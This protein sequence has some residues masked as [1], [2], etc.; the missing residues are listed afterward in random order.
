MSFT[1]AGLKAHMKII[2]FP[3]DGRNCAGDL[4][5]GE[6]G[7]TAT[8]AATPAAKAAAAAT[9]TGSAA[10]AVAMGGAMDGACSNS[11]MG[12]RLPWGTF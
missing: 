7:A 3:A 11:G 9:S 12:G 6:S 1:V 5:A 2:R 8:T 4:V 10:A